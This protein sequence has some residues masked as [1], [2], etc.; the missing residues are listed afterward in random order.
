MR[1]RKSGRRLNRNSAHRSAML[2]NLLVSLVKHE[3]ITTTLGRAKELRIIADKVIT[4]AKRNTSASVT[5]ISRFV[6]AN[7]EEVITKLT[8]ELAPRFADRNGGYTRIIKLGVRRGDGAE[9][10]IIEY[11]PDDE[12]VS[13]SRKSQPKVEAVPVEPVEE[14]KETE[15]SASTEETAFVEE[16][17]EDNGKKG[18]E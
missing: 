16:Q 1:H 18:T 17:T 2:S 8:K 10:A 6:R 13:S 9:T 3:R 4:L 12:F 15:T 11:I 7:R 14:V 5:S